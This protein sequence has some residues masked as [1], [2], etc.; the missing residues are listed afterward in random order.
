LG[1]K[2][3]HRVILG[4][5][6][7]ENIPFYISAAVLAFGALLG[8]KGL[9]DPAWAGKLVRLQAETGQPEGYAEFRSTLGGMFLGLHGAALSCMGLLK[10][11]AG[12]AACLILSAGWLMT[13]LG[14]TVAYCN[15]AECRHPHVV[16]S[17]GIEI[18]AGVL[19]AV[20]P[21]SSLF[22]GV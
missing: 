11:Q 20:W 19:I 5:H 10:E 21:V 9:L 15:D 7:V 2:R 1:P 4:G 22:A 16:M 14:R 17:I 6:N 3:E 13:A 18:V 12:L 8:L